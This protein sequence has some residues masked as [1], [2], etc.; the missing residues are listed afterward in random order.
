VDTVR[1]T[2]RKP[3]TYRI[4]TIPR[5]HSVVIY[6]ELHPVNYFSSCQIFQYGDIGLMFTI[7]GPRFYDAMAAPGALSNLLTRLG[8]VALEGYV[9][10]SHARLMRFA[11]RRVA[12]VEDLHPGA[13]A[14]H[15]MV[16]VRVRV[17]A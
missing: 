5:L 3:P 14:G 6:D 2:T 17:K 13:M 11:L 1:E 8:I 9:T 7:N 12:T 10:P 4:E 15:E 16:W